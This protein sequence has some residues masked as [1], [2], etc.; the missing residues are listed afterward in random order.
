MLASNDLMFLLACSWWKFECE[1]PSY[2]S[3]FV[4]SL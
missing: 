3:C 1:E 4:S 2:L